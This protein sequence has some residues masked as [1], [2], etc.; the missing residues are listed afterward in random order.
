MSNAY[1]F[2]PRMNASKKRIDWDIKEIN[3][4]GYDFVKYEVKK[5]H[6]RNKM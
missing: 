4:E 1:S 2:D 5:K 3:E 6:T